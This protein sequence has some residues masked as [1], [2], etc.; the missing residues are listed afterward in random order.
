MCIPFT[1]NYSVMFITLVTLCQDFFLMLFTVYIIVMLLSNHLLKTD[2]VITTLSDHC[3][4]PEHMSSTF[5]SCCKIT[6]CPSQVITYEGQS[7]LAACTS[8]LLVYYYLR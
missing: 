5:V 4:W 8:S 1:Y 6:L 3:K 7:N 2:N